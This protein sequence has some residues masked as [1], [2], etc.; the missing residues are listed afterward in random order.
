MTTQPPLK[1]RELLIPDQL[2]L[3]RVLLTI[4]KGERAVE[5][6]RQ[7]LARLPSFEP[8]SAFQRIDRDRDGRIT[9]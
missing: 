8:K 9:S 1:R 4:G 5:K 6:Q 3:H 7:D 2:L